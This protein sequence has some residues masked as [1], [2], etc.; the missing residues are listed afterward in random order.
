ML[1]QI[2]KM[3]NFL[4]IVRQLYQKECVP[5]T[6][7]IITNG[8]I[9]NGQREKFANFREMMFLSRHFNILC[10]WRPRTIKKLTHFYRCLRTMLESLKK[11]M[12]WQTISWPEKAIQI[13]LNRARIVFP[14]T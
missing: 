6:E 3:S 5:F 4:K 12:K 10:T 14:L 1:Y 2:L 11:F 8:I 13:K 7:R 9:T